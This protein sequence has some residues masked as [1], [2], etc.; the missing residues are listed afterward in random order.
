MRRHMIASSHQID[1]E[2][3]NA[4]MCR[5][6]GR[7]CVGLPAPIVGLAVACSS[8][9]SRKKVSGFTLVEL[10]ITVA[11]AGVLLALAVPEMRSTIKNTRIKT[12]ASEL[13]AALNTGRSEAIKNR[14]TVVVCSRQSN[15]DPA[16]NACSAG[17]TWTSGWLVFVDAD[18]DGT[19]DATE[20]LVRA[21]SALSSGTTLTVENVDDVA[22]PAAIGL[23]RYRLAGTTQP[24]SR[25]RICD[26]RS[27][28]SGRNI[29]I[30]ATGR[31]AVTPFTCS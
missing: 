12:E 21:R 7:P 3:A 20:T 5:C 18:E 8:S 2:Q 19:L 1:T 31:L 6:A 24:N 16:V 22:S 13:A 28:E 15:S 17:T 9:R 29:D 14:T 10:M 25:L 27:G 26:D 4:C 11:V 23:F 30:N